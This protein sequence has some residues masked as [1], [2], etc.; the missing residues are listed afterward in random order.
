M[1]LGREMAEHV[2]PTCFSDIVHVGGIE[3]IKSK[4]IRCKTRKRGATGVR[5]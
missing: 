1:K 3:E 5:A 4:P 2:G